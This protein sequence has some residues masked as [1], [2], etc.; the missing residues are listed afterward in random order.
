MTD[1]QKVNFATQ[2]LLAALL[3]GLA[4]LM[5][6]LW[7]AERERAD[8]FWLAVLMGARGATVALLFSFISLDGFPLGT[9]RWAFVIVV[10]LG[11][12]AMIELA[13]STF[14]WR[15]PRLRIPFWIM[16]AA[17][18]YPGVY[19]L[20]SFCSDVATLAIVATGWWRG[21]GRRQPGV[22]SATCLLIALLAL[23]QMRSQS[24][25]TLLPMIWARFP[26]VTRLAVTGSAPYPP[27]SWF[28]PPPF[29][30]WRY[31]ASS[32]NAWNGSAS[33]AN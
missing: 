29:P 15:S 9:F 21:G 3:L 23:A 11:L 13:L 32:P 7:L 28:W 10:D 27:S 6:V 4:S 18:E 22:R 2:G 24:G 17:A 1:R 12:V 30:C 25:L 20:P 8:L 19:G 16:V 31:A 5:F 14:R 26:C 33:R